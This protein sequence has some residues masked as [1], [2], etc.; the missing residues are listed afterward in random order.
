MLGE[1][2]REELIQIIG[3]LNDEIWGL[4]E[5]LDEVN[6]SSPP[7]ES[8]VEFLEYE[9]KAHQEANEAEISSLKEMVQIERKRVADLEHTSAGFAAELGE[10]RSQNTELRSLLREQQEI[11]STLDA[12][13]LHR[14]A[15]AADADQ[16][17]CAIKGLELRVKSLQEENTML[18]RQIESKEQRFADDIKRVSSQ[19]AES[20]D[21]SFSAQSFDIE[22]VGKLQAEALSM[23][24]TIQSLSD[25]LNLQVKE[26]QRIHKEFMSGQEAFKM[27][28]RQQAEECALFRT[29]SVSLRTLLN[30]P[31]VSDVIPAVQRLHAQ[32]GEYRRLVAQVSETERH[33][34]DEIVKNRQLQQKFQNPQL[35]ARISALEA[36]NRRL[37]GEIDSQPDFRPTK[38]GDGLIK[39]NAMYK[40]VFDNCTAV[41]QEWAQ[42]TG[43][44][45]VIGR[46]LETFLRGEAID[47][48]VAEFESATTEAITA[49]LTESFIK[50]SDRLT[51]YAALMGNIS[52]TCDRLEDRVG[53]LEAAQKGMMLKMRRSSISSTG[54]RA[55]SRIPTFANAGRL[56]IPLGVRNQAAIE[57]PRRSP[58]SWKEPKQKRFT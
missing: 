39:E 49:I 13:V 10:L 16:L 25:N 52:Q 36:E 4:R 37:H 30:C 53:S 35:T 11:N 27:Q 8:A 21:L 48:I 19:F 18:R 34:A 47:D 41:A 12:K 45:E 58:V 55:G 56:R 22:Y 43:P 3:K 28:S 15:G 51:R 20:V 24:Q 29:V 26:T 38:A 2:T 57:S 42:G 1:P 40:A 46:L 23:K 7:D 14:P 44:V 6:T 31:E 9:R 17:Y 5:K 33:L 50:M 32:E 54:S